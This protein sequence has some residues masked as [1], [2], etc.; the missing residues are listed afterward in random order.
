MKIRY[1]RFYSRSHDRSLLN[2]ERQTF[3]LIFGKNKDKKNVLLKVFTV[4]YF[5]ISNLGMLT[6]PEFEL[7][8]LH[9]CFYILPSDE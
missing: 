1:K 9:I 5:Q 7:N 4:K 8:L 3:R 6:I 2:P